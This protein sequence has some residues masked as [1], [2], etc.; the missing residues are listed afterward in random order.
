MKCHSVP[1]SK[2][3]QLVYETKADLAKSGLK[4]TIVGH[5]GDGTFLLQNV[6]IHCITRNEYQ[7][8][9]TDSSSSVTIKNSNPLA[10]LSTDSSV[11]RLPWMALVCPLSRALSRQMCI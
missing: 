9:S 5:V 8:T 3:P 6:T 7:G 1:V 2:L 10:K 4:S 11:A